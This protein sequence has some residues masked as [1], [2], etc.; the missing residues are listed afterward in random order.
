MIKSY[1]A[2]SVMGEVSK[3]DCSIFLWHINHCRLF[4]AKFI[5]I[6]INSSILN[7]SVKHKHTLSKTFLFHAIQFS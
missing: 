1:S 7:N 3:D 2:L 6:Q 5:S 4:N